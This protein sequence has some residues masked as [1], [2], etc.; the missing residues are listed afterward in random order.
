MNSIMPSNIHDF[1]TNAD[2]CERMALEVRNDDLRQMYADLAKQWREL[3]RH[4][5]KMDRKLAA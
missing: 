3:V 5:C 1:L 4:I 2:H